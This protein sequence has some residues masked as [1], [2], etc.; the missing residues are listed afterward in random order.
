M[1]NKKFVV[2]GIIIGCI[3]VLAGIF[4][5]GKWFHGG[6]GAAPTP[7]PS[8]SVVGG[9]SIAVPVVLNR[10]VYDVALARAI[11]WQ[12][13]AALM[14]MISADT[15]GNAWDFTFVSSKA[16][17]KGFEVVVDGQSVVRTNE[18]M[19]VGGGSALPLNIISPDEAMTEAHAVPGYAKAT[20]VSLEMLYD[21]TARGWYWGMK[22]D[23][24]V[25]ITVKATP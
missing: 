5:I 11:A 1:Q 19:I 3:I 9:G 8:S 16:K 25:T 23:A 7:T 24:G 12:P 20:I 18:I 14:K 22:T 6:T 4:F 17:G 21:A 2:I 15:G 10:S 13:D